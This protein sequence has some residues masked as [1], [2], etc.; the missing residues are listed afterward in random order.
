MPFDPR[1][2]SALSSTGSFT[3]W[4]YVTTDTR[5]GVLAG[6]YFNSVADRLQAGH[7]LIVQAAD[8]M[9]F[10]PVRSNAAVGNGLVLD[11]S[12]PPL[13]LNGY[14]AL[15][16]SFDI[17]PVAAVTRS[18]A[19]GPVPTGLYVGRQFAIGAT[20]SGPVATLI[21]SI[22]NAAGA[23]VAGPL[24]V[25]VAAGGASATFTAPAPGSG[26]RIRVADAAEPLAAQTSA[27]FVV[28]E[29]FALLTETG[30]SITAEQGGDILL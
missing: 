25:A 20:A 11:A 15:G 17:P 7:M 8:S 19:L 13:R 24:P 27:S 2:L 3:L 28:T 6:G 5:A 30:A 29:P 16:F 21:F 23:V 10:L 4:L 26:Y 22:L 1:G 9:N 18:V 12:A 14:A